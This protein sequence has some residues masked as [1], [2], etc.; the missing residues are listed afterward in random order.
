MLVLGR[1]VGEEIHI[2]GGIKIVVTAI[3]GNRV[4][5]GIECPPEKRI[6]RGGLDPQKPTK[7]TGK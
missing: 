4:R 7:E 5:I 3:M 1:K 6:R 2:D